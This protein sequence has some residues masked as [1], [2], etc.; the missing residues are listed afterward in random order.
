MTFNRTE[1]TTTNDADNP[2]VVHL[3]SDTIW[4]VYRRTPNAGLYLQREVNNVRGPETLIADPVTALD[5]VVDPDG[6]RAWIYFVTDG[7]LRRIEVTDKTEHP[8]NQAVQ[9]NSGWYERIEVHAG[10]HGLDTIWGFPDPSSGAVRRD[11]EPL[12]IYPP[13]I[14][15][16]E[17]G[18]GIRTILIQAGPVRYGSILKFRV[19]RDADPAGAGFQ[20]YGE[21]PYPPGAPFV[22]IDV[23]APVGAQR[24]VWAATT[25][26]RPPVA[27]ETCF[28]NRVIETVRSPGS[29]MR[30]SGG[31]MGLNSAWTLTDRTPVKLATPPDSFPLAG[32]AMGLNHQWTITDRTPIKYALPVDSFPLAGGAM[33]LDTR[34]IADGVGIINP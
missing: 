27:R 17:G 28:S 33:G 18:P 9:R 29:L 16:F 3:G 5:V 31:A 34:W 12:A 14:A 2:R 10:G 22:V 24:F 4:Y 32:G 30:G 25:V 1:I 7:S 20:L 13:T 26:G 23:P 11:D 15:I 19:Y 21:V 8:T 6:T